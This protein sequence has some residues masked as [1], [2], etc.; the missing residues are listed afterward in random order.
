M[1]SLYQDNAQLLA[2]LAILAPEGNVRF[3]LVGLIDFLEGTAED[4]VFDRLAI[5]EVLARGI[6]QMNFEMDDDD[7]EAVDL[8][9]LSPEEVI[10][11]FRAQLGTD[12]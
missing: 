12:E 2:A 4:I 7:G 1:G 3:A 6:V 5:F 11:K 8:T 9:D 10:E